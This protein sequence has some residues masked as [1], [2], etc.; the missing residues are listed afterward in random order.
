MADQRGA[1]VGSGKIYLADLDTPEKLVFIKNCSKLEYQIEA[2]ENTQADHT[3]PGGGTDASYS[4][5]KAVN[6][7]YT[8]HHLN[9]ANLARALYG[10]ATD[11]AAGTVTAEAHTAY[12]GAL[13]KFAYPQPSA[14]TLTDS[15]GATT[16]VADTDYQVTAAGVVILEGGAIADATA[17]KANYSYPPHA[18]IQALINSGKNYRM[19]FEGLNEARSGKPQIIE[20][21]KISHSPAGLS[22]IGDD[23]ASLEFTGKALKD[24]TK[25]GAGVSQYLFIQDVD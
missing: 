25:T 18:N 21:Y 20:I 24:S 8:A 3:T 16:Y 6:I 1:W 2:E 13:V 14:V 11:V 15:T 7:S 23:F 22:V 17:V 12:K 4:R 10:S 19:V 9:K 5:I